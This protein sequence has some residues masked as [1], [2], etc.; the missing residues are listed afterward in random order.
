MYQ[1]NATINNEFRPESGVNLVIKGFEDMVIQQP[2]HMH[3]LEKKQDGQTFSI[4]LSPSS[5]GTANRSVKI[6]VANG[7]EKTVTNADFWQVELSGTSDSAP[8]EAQILV[9]RNQQ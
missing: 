5:G 8:C 9:V 4:I 2:Q 6:E 3:A 7:T 1:F